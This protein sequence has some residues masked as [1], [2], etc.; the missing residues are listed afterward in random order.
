MNGKYVIV[1][2]GIAEISPTRRG[3]LSCELNRFSRSWQN[4]EVLGSCWG[5]GNLSEQQ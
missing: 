4:K 3:R 2:V 5:E 1:L